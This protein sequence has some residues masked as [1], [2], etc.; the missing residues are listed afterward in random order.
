[1]EEVVPST[2]KTVREFLEDR[3]T[4]SSGLGRKLRVY[5]ENADN[6]VK[7]AALAMGKLESLQLDGDAKALRALLRIEDYVQDVDHVQVFSG[8][9]RVWFDPQLLQGSDC[10]P[11]ECPAWLT[12]QR[13]YVRDRVYS[14]ATA[15]DPISVIKLQNLRR[16]PRHVD[17]TDIHN[18]KLTAATTKVL[19]ELK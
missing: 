12:A 17:Q 3:V 19:N 11:S 18:I 4:L 16:A 1:M 8:F 6:E 15:K 2:F 14:N 13:R 7:D 9:S 10:R 5:F